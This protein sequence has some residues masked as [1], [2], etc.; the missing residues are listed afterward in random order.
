MKQLA[1]LVCLP[2]LLLSFASRAEETPTPDLARE[3][4]WARA[5]WPDEFKG[6]RFETQLPRLLSWVPGKGATAAYLFTREEAC[7]RVELSRRQIGGSVRS[8]LEG[9]LISSERIEDRHRVRDYTIVMIGDQLELESGFSGTESRGADGKWRSEGYGGGTAEPTIY[10]ALSSVDGRVAHFDGQPLQLVDFCAGPVEWLTC[11]SGGEHP[12]ERCEQVG[13]FLVDVGSSWTRGRDYGK[14]PV[15]CHDACP[16][17]SKAPAMARMD[18]LSVRVSLWRFAENPT[19]ESATL[20]RLHADCL[21]EHP[22][23]SR[24]R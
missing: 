14:R 17:Y 4:A 24:P 19:A 21:R 11:P 6:V 7:G 15:A 3:I 10:G 20:Y 2:V 18:R 8:A 1:V 9:K 23:T 13:V 12:C 16:T 22:V 5:G